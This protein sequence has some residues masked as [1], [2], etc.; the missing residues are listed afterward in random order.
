MYGERWRDR[1][2]TGII[3]MLICVCFPLSVAIA[4]ISIGSYC[5]LSVASLQQQIQQTQDLISIIDQYKNDPSTL[6]QQLEAKRAEF[7]QAK[8][9]LYSSYGTTAE[10]FVTY[11]GKNGDAV[12]AYLEAHPDIKQQIDD[13]SA[14]LQSLMEQEEAL[15][16]P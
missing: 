8:D 16:A 10:E 1:I 14:Q 9:E 11:M 5:D 7:D 13:L 3:T 4:E 2:V 6:N 12:K 15:M